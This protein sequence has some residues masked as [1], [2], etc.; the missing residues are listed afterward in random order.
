VTSI[1]VRDSQTPNGLWKAHLQKSVPSANLL[2]TAAA[3][4]RRP[5]RLIAH[6]T[7]RR[8]RPGVQFVRPRQHCGTA[9][10]TIVGDRGVTP[11]TTA[12]VLDA[13][14]AEAAAGC[15]GASHAHHGS[16]DGTMTFLVDGGCAAAAV[17]AG[18]NDAGASPLAAV[19]AGGAHARGRAG[20]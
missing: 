20:P 8:H 1:A 13:M 2:T 9:R 7:Q 6:D 10:C 15:G 4:F 18:G 3:T 11:G 12:D 17:A 14:D 19:A 16:G 5:P